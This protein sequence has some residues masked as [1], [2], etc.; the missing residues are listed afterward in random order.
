MDKYAVI[1]RAVF[2]HHKT[3]DTLKMNTMMLKEL[4]EEGSKLLELQ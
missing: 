3:A 1:H 2:E 4:M